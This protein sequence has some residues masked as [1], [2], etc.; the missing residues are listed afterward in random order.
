[1]ELDGWT[2]CWDAMPEKPG[3]YLVEDREGNRFKADAH[4]SF[5]NMVWTVGRRDKGYDICWWKEIKESS[6]KNLSR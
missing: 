6:K 5:G 4:I 2:N 3:T 1:M